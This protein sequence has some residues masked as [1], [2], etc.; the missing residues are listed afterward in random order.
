MR[1]PTDTQ[2]PLAKT[3]PACGAIVT[4]RSDS[5]Y[6]SP[7]CRHRGYYQRSREATLAKRAER[8]REDATYR[9]KI[10]NHRLALAAY[11]EEQPCETCGTLPTDRH[12]DDDS[13]PLLIRWLCRSCHK[14]W[15]NQ[16]GGSDA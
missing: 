3:C 8:Y 4:G 14:L 16:N 12:H 13:Q 1:G 15:H 6:C 7:N 10:R 5:I 11:P 2:L 9:A